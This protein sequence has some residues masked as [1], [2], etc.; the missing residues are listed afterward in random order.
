[1]VGVWEGCGEC[2]GMREAV[3]EEGGWCSVLSG[4]L[5]DGGDSVGVGVGVGA[6]GSGVDP[7]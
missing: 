7:L 4:P 3:A 2:G 6:G 5:E 1:M